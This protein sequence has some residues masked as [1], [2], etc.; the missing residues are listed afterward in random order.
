MN[1]PVTS[2]REIQRQH[3][4]AVV[5][6]FLDWYRQ[7]RKVDFKVISEPEK[8]APE[9]I[10]RSKRLTR[11][12]EVTDAFWSEGWAQDEYSYATPGRIHVPID[13]GFAA[14]PD[15]TFAKK[16]VAAL[17]NKLSKNSYLDVVRD[18]GT[19][20]LVVNIEYPLFTNQTLM[21]M[22]A[23]WDTGKPWPNLGCFREVFLR[24]RTSTGP[25]F[26]RWKV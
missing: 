12:V 19:G 20:F 16:F 7:H 1:Q 13:T 4:R 8:R 15:E 9:A 25:A 22:K 3:E 14:S 17:S 2:R 5:A 26:F 10:I 23:S 6:D 21:E 11:W 24:R 18:Y